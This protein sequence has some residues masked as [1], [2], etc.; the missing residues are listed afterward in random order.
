MER[1]AL[2]H[3]EDNM[4]LR[5]KGH[6]MHPAQVHYTVIGNLINGRIDLVYIKG[7]RIGTT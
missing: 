5:L 7:N 1:Q 2:I 3:Q 6:F 4:F